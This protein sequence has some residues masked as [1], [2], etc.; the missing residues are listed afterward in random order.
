MT[1]LKPKY[2]SVK[3]GNLFWGP[4]A[5]ARKLGFTGE[6]L[7]PDSN[8]ARAKADELNVRL[9]EALPL[10]GTTDKSGHYPPGSLGDWFLTWTTKEPFLRKAPGTRAEF[11][12]AWKRIGPALGAM[13]IDQISPAD[14]EVFQ[15]F[16]E[17]ETTPYRRWSIVKKLRGIFNAA[18]VYNIVQRTPAMTLPNPQPPAREQVLPFGFTAAVAAKAFEMEH[19][20][21]SLIVRLM[22]EAAVSPIDARSVKATMLIP[23]GSGGYLSR[24]RTKTSAGTANSLSDELWHDIQAYMKANPAIGEVFRRKDGTAW[25][26]RA[27]NY[28]FALVRAAAGY[29]SGLKAMDIRRTA[30]LEA[31]LGGASKE[32]RAAFLAN[33]LDVNAKL[34]AAYTPDTVEGSEEIARKREIGRQMLRNVG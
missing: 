21:L 3:N 18:I 6:A 25:N 1:L 9:K 11:H 17:N 15:I 2:T 12:E 31:H 8:A 32:D 26:R 13:Q 19:H 4:P 7:G 27:F 5:W 24:P 30:N 14:C 29:P 16:L 20:G 10:R 23:R 22:Y 34:H 28:D 33:T